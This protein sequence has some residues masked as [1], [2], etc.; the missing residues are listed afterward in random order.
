MNAEIQLDESWFLLQSLFHKVNYK[1]KREVA[2][3]F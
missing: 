3:N 2:S 1:V